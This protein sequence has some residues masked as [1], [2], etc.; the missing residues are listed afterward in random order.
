MIISIYNKNVNNSQNNLRIIQVLNY[1]CVIK[2][3][4]VID[5]AI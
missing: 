4:C 2:C 3:E 1:K 5:K